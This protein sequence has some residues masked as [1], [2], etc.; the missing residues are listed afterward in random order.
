[1]A[2]HNCMNMSYTGLV[3]ARSDC[4]WTP[5]EQ[6]MMCEDD[7]RSPTVTRRPQLSGLQ[8]KTHD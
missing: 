4:S 1:M 2:L 3:S 8:L 6:R 5:L 7:V